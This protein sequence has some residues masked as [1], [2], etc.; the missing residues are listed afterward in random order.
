[1]SDYDPGT[2]ILDQAWLKRKL[3]ADRAQEK[4]AR[5]ERAYEQSREQAKSAFEEA[6]G[7]EPSEYELDELVEEL[8]KQE[9]SAKLA[10]NKA[11]ARG[12]IRQYF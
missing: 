4:E 1:M 9:V 10:A 12:Q 2:Q 7:T 3:E 5:Q 6:T 11:Q 8:Q